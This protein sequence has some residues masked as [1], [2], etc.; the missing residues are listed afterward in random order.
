MRTSAALLLLAFAGF[1]SAQELGTLFHTPKERETLERLRRGEPVAGP[2]QEIFARPDPVVIGYVKRSDGK[3][4]VFLD[5]QPYAARGGRM[6]GLLEPRIIE[7]YEPA[8]LPAEPIA[9]AVPERRE[10]AGKSV[11][12]KKAPAARPRDDKEE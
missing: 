2:G 11:P 9:P 8:P 12:P 1:A 5:K 10:L 6:Q 4:T 7:R 3:S